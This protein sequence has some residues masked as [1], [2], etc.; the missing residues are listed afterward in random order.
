M[1]FTV[2][3]RQRWSK[4]INSREKLHFLLFFVQKFRKFMMGLLIKEFNFFL[5]FHKNERLF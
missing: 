5:P 1:V 3:S 4:G 2:I